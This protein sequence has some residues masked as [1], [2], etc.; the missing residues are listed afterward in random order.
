MAHNCR[1]TG[2]VSYDKNKNEKFTL[3]SICI[4]CYSII[5]EGWCSVSRSIPDILAISFGT[6]RGWDV[7]RGCTVDGWFDMFPAS[8]P[9]LILK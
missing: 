4:A 5:E 6:L 1:Q 9:K 8:L 3:F 7:D 2:H